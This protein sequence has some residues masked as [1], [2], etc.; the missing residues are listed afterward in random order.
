MNGVLLQLC[1]ANR[2]SEGRVN[3]LFARAVLAALSAD[4]DSFAEL[5]AALG[6]YVKRDGDHR[7]LSFLDEPLAGASASTRDDDLLW[8]DLAGRVVAY[9]GERLEVA[10]FGDVKYLEADEL[11]EVTLSFR[12][13]SHW[14]LCPWDDQVPVVARQRREQRE[15][16]PPLDVRQVLYGQLPHGL[17]RELVQG[18]ESLGDDPIREV[19][20]RWLLTPRADLNGATP[21][22]ML[23][24]H[25]DEMVDEISARCW[26]W[27]VLGVCPPPLPEGSLAVTHGV[28]G[29]HEFVLY[30]DL[31]RR[32]LGAALTASTEVARDEEALATLMTRVRDEWWELANEEELHGRTPRQLVDDERRRVPWAMSPQEAMID[33]DCPLCRMMAEQSDSPYFCHL[34]ASGFD[35]RF[36]FSPIRTRE[37][38]EADEADCRAFHE[39]LQDSTDDDDDGSLMPA[40]AVSADRAAWRSCR[41]APPEIAHLSP[42]QQ[43]GVWQFRI[44]AQLMELRDDVRDDMDDKGLVEKLIGHI[45]D[46]REAV[47]QKAGWLADTCLNQATHQLDELVDRRDELA[48]KFHDV[49]HSLQMLRQNCVVVLTDC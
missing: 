43:F 45:E 35:D 23:V 18:R 9:R 28:I 48:A 42:A 33:H 3:H 5:E 13:R 36:A 7:L 27:S 2:V 24:E 10:S 38:W 17:A 47:R 46:V 11:R 25:L 44:L 15:A 26:E 20:E 37:E 39:R 6:R 30:Y 4:P 12:L 8:I 21:R 49:R 40:T 41:V 16:H 14:L 22:E 32:L 34:D 1:D 31:V 19:H 29:M